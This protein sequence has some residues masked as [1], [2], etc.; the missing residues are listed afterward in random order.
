MIIHYKILKNIN[1]IHI[2]LK[3]KLFHKGLPLMFVQ[4]DLFKMV[5]Y[6][7]DDRSKLNLHILHIMYSLCI[8]INCNITFSFFL[9]HPHII[10]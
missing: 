1:F 7:E 2:H 9:N 4:C 6:F 3:L 5:T 8:I 10:M